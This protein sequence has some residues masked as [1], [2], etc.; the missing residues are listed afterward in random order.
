M[1]ECTVFQL[2]KNSLPIPVDLIAQQMERR[3]SIPKVRVQIP[4]ES[5]FFSWLWQCQI[6]MKNF[7]SC[8][9][10]RMILKWSNCSRRWLRVSIPHLPATRSSLFREVVRK[11]NY[12]LLPIVACQTSFVTTWFKTHALFTIP[13]SFVHFHSV[14]TIKIRDPL[15]WTIVPQ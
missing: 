3:T 2:N 7:C 13:M 5:T 8:I 14:F 6:I 4:L 12:L 9:S 10:L 15:A 11:R 1:R